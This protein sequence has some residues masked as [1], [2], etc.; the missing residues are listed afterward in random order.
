MSAREVTLFGGSPWGFRMHGGCDT[1]QPL[2]ISRVNPGS[3]AAQ[4]GVREG[5]LISNIN[6]KSTRDLTNSEA[7]ALLRNSG[8]QLK[9]GLNQ[10]NIGSPKRRIYKSSLQENTTTEIQNKTTTRTITRTRT[11]AEKNVANDTKVEQS[12]TNQNGALKSCPDEQGSDVKKGYC[13]LSDYAS[14]AED[15]SKVG[16]PQGK[17]GGRTRNR[18]RRNR[19]R[20]NRPSL[21]RPSANVA[22]SPRNVE[23]RRFDEQLSA[24][25]RNGGDD[26]D[27]NDS[28]TNDSISENADPIEAGGSLSPRYRFRP[29]DRRRVEKIELKESRPGIIEITTVSSLP[30][31][32]TIGH[33][34]GVGILE[35]G[36]GERTTVTISEPVESIRPFPVCSSTKLSSANG[37]RLEIREVDDSDTEVDCRPTIV[38]FEPAVER[39]PIEGPR[40]FEVLEESKSYGRVGQQFVPRKKFSKPE[41]ES[42]TSMCATVM[43][44]D[45]ERKLRNFIEG[46]QLPTFS[47]EATED[48]GRPLE[49]NVSRDVSTEE[50]KSVEKTAV[51][52]RRKMRKRAMSTASHY[53]RNFLDIIQEEGERLSEDEAQHIRDFINEEISKYRRQDRHSAEEAIDDTEA[54]QDDPEKFDRASDKLQWD[55]KIKI[56]TTEDDIPELHSCDKVNNREEVEQNIEPSCAKNVANPEMQITQNIISIKVTNET[57]DTPS[58]G[59]ME[60]VEANATQDNLGIENRIEILENDAGNNVGGERLA[61]NKEENADEKSTTVKSIVNDANKAENN[62]LLTKVETLAESSEK[63]DVSLKDFTV[64]RTVTDNPSVSRKEDETDS[65]SS[66]SA[67]KRP[68][69]LPPRRSSSFGHESQRPPALPEIDYISS[70]ASIHQQQPLD[71]N[72]ESTNLLA[73]KRGNL[74]AEEDESPRRPEL[75]KTCC[76][77]SSTWGKIFEGSSSGRWRES[78]STIIDENC[79]KQ[80]D[81]WKKNAED[82]RSITS[83]GIRDDDPTRSRDVGTRGVSLA[84]ATS[85]EITCRGEGKPAATLVAAATHDR[86]A[87]PSRQEG[88]AEVHRCF[89][90]HRHDPGKKNSTIDGS[91]KD[92]KSDIGPDF[93]TMGSSS[94][95]NTKGKSER[96]GRNVKSTS[97]FLHSER[98]TKSEKKTETRIIERHEE[99]S[100]ANQR[101]SLRDSKYSTWESKREERHEERHEEETRSL[102]RR[103]N[104]R[105]SSDDEA[106][107][108]RLD[109]SASK[110]PSPEGDVHDSSSSTTSLSTV[111]HRSLEAL[112]TDISATAYETKNNSK[113]E[114]KEESLL[115]R[116]LTLMKSAGEIADETSAGNSESPQPVPYSPVEDLYYVP[117]NDAEDVGEK[118]LKDTSRPPSSLRELCVKRILSMPFG[119]QMIDEITAPKLN[120]FENLR[121]LQRFVNDVPRTRARQQYNDNAQRLK[122]MHGVSDA[123]PRGLTKMPDGSESPLRPNDIVNAL[124]DRTRSSSVNI[125]LSES[126]GEMEERW[127]ALSTS[128]DP[129]LLVCLSPSQQASRIRASADTLLD[130]HRKFLNRYSYREQQPRCVP[131]PRY[132]VEIRP[133]K[134][135]DDASKAS[136]RATNRDATV[137]RWSSRLLEIIKEERKD[138]TKTITENKVPDSLEHSEGQENL[139]AVRSNDWSNLA[140]RD[141]RRSATA[142][143]LFLAAARGEDGESSDDKP[144]GHV[145]DR[146]RITTRSNVAETDEHCPLANGAA[147]VRDSERSFA[148]KNAFALNSAI[149]DRLSMDVTGKRTP[150]L[151]RTTD[152]GKHVNPALIDDRLEVP[153]LPKRTVTVDRSCIDTTSIFDQNPPRSHLERRRSR[154]ETE[155]LK[156]V[157]AVEIMD[158]LKTLQTETHGDSTAR[159]G[160]LPQEYFVQQLKYIELLEEQL[161]N[162][163]LAEEEERKAFEE[164]QTHFHRTKGDDDARKSSIEETEKKSSVSFERKIP[165]FLDVPDGT[166]DGKSAENEQQK[167]TRS[168]EEKRFENNTC[169]SEPEIQREQ[170]REKSRNVEK[171]RTETIDKAGSRQFSRKVSHENGIHEETSESIEREECHVITQTGNVKRLSENGTSERE[172]R[173]KEETRTTEKPRNTSGVSNEEETRSCKKTV[174][175][176][177]RPTRLPTN[178]EAFRQRM[179]DEYVD[180]VLERQERKSHKVVKISSREDIGRKTDGDMSAMAREFIEKAR[181]R[182]NKFGIDLDESGTDREEDE[183]DVINAKFLI[184]GKELR[185]ASGKLPK[186][187]REFLKMSTVSDD[188]E[189]GIGCGKARDNDSDCLLHEIDKALK[190][191]RGFLLEQE[192]VMFAPTFKASSAKPGVWSPGQTPAGKEP[193]PVRT[194]EPQKNEPIPPVWTPASAGASPVAERKE[195]RPVPFESPVL[196]RKKQPKEEEAPPPPW[197]NEEEKRTLSS[198]SV[199][200]SSSTSR[201]VNS[202]SAPSQ[203]LNALASAPRLPRAQNPTITLLQKAREG[204]LPKGAAYLEESESIDNRPSSDER[205]LISP[206]EII[207]TVKKEYESEPEAENEAPKKMA[208]LGPRKFEGIG[209]VTKEGIPLVLRSEV[210]ENNQAKWYKRMYDSLHRA[211]KNDDYVTVKYK[212]RRGGRY[213]YGSS[214]G[215][216]SEPEPRAYSDRSITLDSR[217]RLRNK[218]NDFTTATMPRKNGA[219]R[220]STEIYKNQPGRIEDYEPGRS[221]IAEKEAKEWWDEV[222][223]IFD[224]WLNENGRPQHAQT[225]MESLRGD[226]RQSRVLSLS[227]RPEDSPFDQRSH[228]RVAAKPYIT[229]ALKESGYES[230][231]TLVFRRKEDINPLSLLEQRLAYKTVQSGGDVPLHGLR[232]PAPERPK[233][234]SEIEYFPI[235]PTLT[236]IR[237]HRR[238]ASSSTSFV[239]SSFSQAL[240]PVPFSA[241]S[242]SPPVMRASPRGSPSRAMSVSRPPSPPRRRSSRHSRTLKLYSESARLIDSSQSSSKP[243]HEQCF[244][245]TDSVTS[246]RSLRE[247]FCSNLER[248]RRNREQFHSAIITRTTSSSPV[249]TSKTTKAS[250]FLSN[251]FNKRKSDPCLSQ[252]QFE[253]SKKLS[254]PSSTTK[255][256]IYSLTSPRTI[257]ESSTKIDKL[258]TVKVPSRY[259]S[260]SK[261]RQ[262]SPERG[263]I[264]TRSDH[265]LTSTKREKL[266][267]TKKEQEQS[268]RRLSKSPAEISLPIEARKVLQKQRE[269]EVR[270]VQTRVHSS[271]TVIKSSTIPYSSN[272]QKRSVD[273]SLKIAVA[274]SPKGQEFLRKT[275]EQSAPARRTLSSQL[276]SPIKSTSQI[277]KKILSEPK[278]TKIIAKPP[279]KL[280]VSKE[281]LRSVSS[282]CSEVNSEINRR[283][284]PREKPQTIVKISVKKPEMIRMG[285]N[286]NRKKMEARKKM[287]KDKKNSDQV[288]ASTSMNGWRE[289]AE[290]E[291]I[292]LLRRVEKMVPTVEQE[293][294]KDQIVPLTVEEIKRHQEATRTDTFFQN[295]FLRNSSVSA[296]Q[297]HA[298]TR[299]SLVGERAKMFQDIARESFKSEPSLKSL[300]VYLAHKRPVS[301]SKFKNWE[302]ESAVSSRSS[303]PYGVCWPGRSVLQKVSKFDSLLGIDELSSSTT[304]RNRSPELSREHVKERS[305]S[306]PPLKTLPE[307]RESSPRSSSPSPAR[308]QA[309]RRICVSKQDNAN[310]PLTITSKKARARSA[311]EAEDAKRKMDG[312]SL[313]LTKS[314]GS[315]SSADREDYQ[316]YI[317]EL[318]HHRRKSKRYKDLRDFYAS[319]SRMDQLERTFSSGDLR[320]RM[321]NEEIIDYDR[322]KRVRSKEKAEQELKELYGKLK[323]V[324]RDKDFLFSA[325]DVDKFRWHGDC[326]LRCKERSVEDI[327]QYFKRLESEGNELESSRLAVISSQKDTY[328]PLW[329]GSSVVNVA[330]TMQKK[331]NASRDADR[332]ADYHPSLQ[333]SLG[334]SKKFWSSLSIEQVAILKKQLNEIYGSDN[335]QKSTCRSNGEIVEAPHEINEDQQSVNEKRDAAKTETLTSY[336]IIVPPEGDSKDDSKSLHVRCHSMIATNESPMLKGQSC[337]A[338]RVEGI[339][340]KSDSIGRLKGLERSESEKSVSP[341][342]TE[343]EKKRLSLTLGKEVLDKMTRRRLSAP[344]APRE[345]RGSIAA[346]LAIEKMPK[347]SSTKSTARTVCAS[348]TPSVASTSPRTCYSLETSYDDSTKSKDKN[349]FLL[350]LTP[351]NESPSDKQRVETVLEEWSKK[352]PLLAMV[353]PSEKA[354]SNKVVSGSEVDSMTESSEAS[355]KTV[356]QRDGVIEV[357]DVSRKIEFFENVERRGEWQR[358]AATTMFRDKKKLSSSQSVADLKEL[359]GEIESAKY[360]PFGGRIDRSRSTSPREKTIGE[361][362]KADDSPTL[363]EMGMRRQQQRRSFR[364]CS[365][366]REH[367]GRP[368]SVSPCRAT[369]RSNSSCSVDSGSGW[370][371]SSSPDPER[372]WR[373]YLKLVRNGAVRRLRA[374]FES[375]EDLSRRVKVAP[376][377]KRFRSDPELARCLLKRTS[378]E[379][380][381]DTSRKSHERDVDVAWLRRRFETTRR[382][383]P[384]GRRG[385]SPPIPR[386]PLR[387]D[388]LSMPHIDVISKTAELKEPQVTSTVT[389]HVARRAETKEL[390]ARRPVCRMRRRFESPDIAGRTSIMGEMFTSAPDVR[391]LR[392]IAPY[393][394]GKWVAHRYPSRR[395]NMRSLSSPADLEIHRGSSKTRFSSPGGDRKRPERPRATS[396]SPTRP[397]APASILKSSQTIAFA[398]QPFDP[399]KHRPRFRYQPPPPPPSPIAA[400]KRR[401][402]WPTM[403]V[404]TAR[405]TVTFEEYS[406]APPPPPKSQHCRDDRQESPRRYVEGEVTIHY[407]S[408]VR[409]EAKEPLSEEELARRSAENM[410]RVYQEER[411]RKYLQEL[412]DIDSRRHTDNF[413]PSQKSPIP[414]NRYDDFVDDLSQRSRSQD[415]T[416]EPRLVARALYN[417]VGQSSRELTFRRGDIIF[418][419]RQ[420]DKNWYE[421]EY[422]AMIGLFPSNYVEI[423][424]YDGTMRTTP[425]K[426]HEGQARAKF[427]FIA[428]TNLELSLV[429]GELVVLTRRVDENWYEGRIGNRKG[430][431]PISY[432]EVITE[433]GHRSET[434]IQNKPVAS[435]AAHS[436]LAN[437]SSGGKLSMG[438]HHY[439]PSIPVNINTTQP[440]YNSLPRMGGSKLHVSQLSETLHIDTHSE[441]I[442]YRALYNYKPQN[443]DELELK[444]GDT[445]YVMEKC[446]DGWYVGSSQRTGYFGTFPGNYVERL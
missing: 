87:P 206:G 141:N 99:S 425:K 21:Q 220:Y 295:L 288:D 171:T 137:E 380:T 211:D 57:D 286:G 229:H 272:K 224:G 192:N 283:K 139:K 121:T 103:R 415:Q 186:H 143:E 353:I 221:S 327:L 182:L 48:D 43:P 278:K 417:F 26:D 240:R 402:W 299:K 54:K 64:T 309:P 363:S 104:A 345:T 179:Y 302:R 424:P 405:P 38:E 399:D 36:N 39:E 358:E 114:T 269:K 376:A 303:S 434:P 403:P 227:Y 151:R 381:R 413:I 81:T 270:D 316:Q 59:S 251:A 389:N 74:E 174:D 393:L 406:N 294:T 429:K 31:E 332:S 66:V 250:G 109:V 375:A 76:Q 248:H 58:H 372:Y 324:Q 364:S 183:A 7:H 82:G 292:K 334:G 289:I 408:P 266:R 154:H 32:A 261:E 242:R 348:D 373:A 106:S 162:V 258:A 35:T 44:K 176:A 11:E 5:D 14:D 157:A 243:R 235:S 298:A 245:R 368:H 150:P 9:L 312:S 323:N 175:V 73:R 237:V 196:S 306:E 18:G 379:A 17:N 65:S 374:R 91:S 173:I 160:S 311:G 133:I 215:Y 338:T 197:K 239:F 271:G 446:D 148:A 394:A 321:K 181:N 346:A 107:S 230:D 435:P 325:K 149:V 111:K 184:D 340:K 88:E 438:P 360:G 78:A 20:R 423:L 395:D 277:A 128:E 156:Q 112:L 69:P 433:P 421:G 365:R 359:F 336:E 120:I 326:G 232:K 315:L 94:T 145:M 204:Q 273:K 180:K 200:E 305:L 135:D 207:Y 12:Y 392:D 290:K 138:G 96:E 350:V 155:K 29:D 125:E 384:R 152:P 383:R 62:K 126:E 61:N 330:T 67:T 409:T 15:I 301:N 262:R 339:L 387:R 328:K 430:I 291:D 263:Q 247:K 390:E 400:R 169:R 265:P 41:T 16:M 377:P 228:A 40:S 391:E 343:L 217:R 55:V 257:R 404:Y 241:A 212:S 264:S 317:L 170:W 23:Q 386:M 244:A 42:P 414:L 199:Y 341:P 131:V 134:E 191:S 140:G 432:V 75:P 314:T 385:E 331:A 209:P 234:D 117:L 313:S 34:A 436:L 308:S 382:G 108:Q 124:S 342:M 420:V 205:P 142:N 347:K 231:S 189:G 116:K 188:D 282:S 79:V 418:V 344:L 178:G 198:R 113:N 419:R 30:L 46:L 320:P 279:E 100:N 136:S 246:I 77:G 352:P 93:S 254:S 146:L 53:A 110:N 297:S 238:S 410:R 123:R 68:P 441:P 443:D 122:A 163:I 1:H 445:V 322:W 115:K 10:E 25:S 233:D 371:R 60:I 268:C 185:D 355:V 437:G 202:H 329:R 13:V 130:L 195:F 2:R 132:R 45:V 105:N 22:E 83:S 300:S 422:N 370:L 187:L 333:R 201:I 431:F 98:M 190:I 24:S 90:S 92:D 214:S 285:V 218:E 118:I 253:G 213:G 274:V 71:A 362:R 439:V 225:R 119:W 276:K 444:E 161:K 216:L 396:S 50:S 401:S 249:I 356:V 367:D 222:M 85:T 357:E 27:D 193:S 177:R 369:T 236:R 318:L 84:N 281:S 442:P 260:V 293:P 407:R 226:V 310:I 361:R 159:R 426:A 304:L 440:H 284:R 52:S 388:N 80:A 3:K 428:Q 165:K 366:E 354:R 412:H 8:E 259:T 153:P 319:L 296:V 144:S 47:E 194:K 267:L 252:S 147:I 168:H 6:G 223:D 411:R 33:I 287:Q 256:Y 127:R 63:R 56:D 208:D 398:G 129:R 275:S 37:N 335:L 397:R 102:S 28:K 158:K 95:K 97:S 4:Q 19:H 101:D 167:Y 51:T 203:G 172:D 49:R 378:E 280:L 349:D 427:N 416:P 72:D 70:V 219:L 255:S 210:K 166:T 337:D 307:S 86:S 89:P 164:F 351:N